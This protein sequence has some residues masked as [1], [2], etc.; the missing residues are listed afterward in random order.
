[1]DIRYLI[2]KCFSPWSFLTHIKNHMGLE[3]FFW[4]E[5]LFVGQKNVA[6]IDLALNSV[7]ENQSKL[8]QRFFIMFRSIW[9]RDFFYVKSLVGI[10]FDWDFFPETNFLKSIWR[11]RKSLKIDHKLVKESPWCFEAYDCII[12][13][14]PKSYRNN[15]R[16][17]KI[18]TQKH[19]FGP[20]KLSKS[21]SFFWYDQ[22][23]FYMILWK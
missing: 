17:T 3:G 11:L 2:P 9:P 5:S 20:K 12:F 7:S 23:P 6:W 21:K 16:L 1:M 13:F 18:N 14:C 4:I 19:V 8:A 10:P 15:T 22:R